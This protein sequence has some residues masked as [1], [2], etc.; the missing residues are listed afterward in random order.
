MLGKKMGALYELDNHLGKNLSMTLK[1][2]TGVADSSA[3]DQ[4]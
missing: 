3:C 1:L 2:G 4:I